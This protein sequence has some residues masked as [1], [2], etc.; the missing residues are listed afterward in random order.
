MNMNDTIECT[1]LIYTMIYTGSASRNIRSS[2]N[3]YH[4]AS[5]NVDCRRLVRIVKFVVGS[6]VKQGG[7]PQNPSF[8]LARF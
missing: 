2:V 5:S 7:V 8:H 3:D 1:I 6:L 4:G